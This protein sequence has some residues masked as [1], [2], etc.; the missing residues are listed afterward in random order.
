MTLIS[1]RTG[2]TREHWERL[3]DATLLAVR[4]YGSE[5]HARIDLPGRASRSGRRSDG[6]EGFARTFLL[7]GFRLAMSGQDDPHGHA[8]WYAAGLAAGTDPASDERWPSFAE[9]GQAKVECASIAIALHESRPWIWDRLD[10]RTRRN[11][12]A[13]MSEFLGAPTPDN[14]W[15]WFRA[16]TEAFL[17]SVGGPWR[18]DDIAHAVVRTDAWY[19]G[20]G[21]YSDGATVDGRLRNVDHYNGWA[22][23]FYPLWYCRV[24]GPDAEPGLLD[25]YRARL[26]RYL[27]DAV[28]LVGGDGAP[29][30][31]GRSLT[32]RYAMTVPFWA[33][34]IFDASPLAPG[35]TRRLA[36]G[37]VRHF[38]DA[39][40]FDEA[41]LLP[42]GWHGRFVEMREPYSGPGSPYWSSKAFAGLVLPPDHP[43]WTAVEE[44]LPIEL[45]DTSMAL[46]APRWL[47]SGTRADGVVRVVQHGADHTA[48]DRLSI[49]V[50]GYARQG[51]ATH[52]APWYGTATT[53]LESHVALLAPD[54]RA[55]HRS[56]SLPVSLTAD[57][58]VSRYRAHWWRP[59]GRSPTYRPNSD[60]GAVFEVGPW[61]TVASLVRGA[62][63]LRLARVSCAAPGDLGDEWPE[64]AG[65][66]TIR[67][68]GWALAADVPFEPSADDRGA[69]TR[70]ADGLASTVLDIRGLTSSGCAASEG[71]DPLGRYSYVPWVASAGP[72]RFGEVYAALIVLS[73]ELA[74]PRLA[75]GLTLDVRDDTVVVHWP[76]GHRG[77]VRL[78]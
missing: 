37:V 20:D 16:V 75:A 45:G 9:T 70:R 63:E 34:A 61:V 47:V 71:V 39:G 72:V 62:L 2:W 68:G 11:V 52:A 22:M 14:N 44:P 67:F 73:G 59:D 49:D 48:T 50:P 76:D 40:C 4:P 7:A 33:G 18:T 55:S 28:H 51:Y 21:W 25:T 8:E 23:H 6:L 26:S 12:V 31:H 53:P 36:S 17:R 42:L 58:G 32:Y 30:I 54:G 74:G 65:P 60:D 24:S 78:A 69:W 57:A 77:E 46:Q 38:V 66:F 1:P 64:L 3:A 15:T 19:A 13:W 35:L 43:V 29:L 41:G 5:G 56:P 10:D 27:T